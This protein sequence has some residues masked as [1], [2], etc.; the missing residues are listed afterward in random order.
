MRA[1]QGNRRQ[2][3]RLAG[4]LR[5]AANLGHKG[6]KDRHP[7]QVGLGAG[8]G[9]FQSFPPNLQGV[10]V[11]DLDRNVGRLQASA[12]LSQPQRGRD[13]VPHHLPGY[14]RGF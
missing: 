7:Y 10:G 8:D 1:A 12:K 2:R 6:G 11:Q 14:L 9:C 3:R 13:D 4:N 5:G